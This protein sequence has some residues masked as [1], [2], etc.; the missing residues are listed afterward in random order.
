MSRSTR[1]KPGQKAPSTAVYAATR[2]KKLVVVN[3]GERLPPTPT[4]GAAW[5]K[6]R[7]LP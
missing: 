3:Q 1:L 7:Q 5:K 6:Q 4:K 2:G